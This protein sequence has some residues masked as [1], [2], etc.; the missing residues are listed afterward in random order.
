[1][2]LGCAL[3]S[4]W[5]AR[6]LDALTLGEDTAQSMGLSLTQLR[7]AFLTLLSLATGAAVAQVGVV[8]FVGLIAPHLVR[9]TAAMDHR[10]LLWS[11]MLCGGTLLQC[12]DLLSRWLIRP[13]EL[14]VGVLTAC[15]GGG[16][17]LVLMWRRG[18][19]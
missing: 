19:T 3:L 6:G 9:Q 4:L 5:L 16:Y 2:L 1:V 14:P 17:L 12:A 15:L 8:S 10:R 7:L 18:R 11:A 13:T